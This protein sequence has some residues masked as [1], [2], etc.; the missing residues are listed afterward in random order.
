MFNTLRTHMKKIFL[1]LIVLILPAFCF[2][3]IG[4]FMRDETRK[5]AG[6][7]YGKKI[8][9]GDLAKMRSECMLSALILYGKRYGDLAQY[10]D[11]NKQAWERMLLLDEARRLGISISDDELAV[12]LQSL[13][14]VEGKFDKSRYD[15]FVKQTGVNPIILERN[16]RDTMTIGRLT[17]TIADSAVVSAK[18]IDEALER[19]TE[20]RT[21]GYAALKDTTYKRDDIFVP[22]Q[23]IQAYYAANGWEF[24]VPDKVKAAY[25]FIP[26][27]DFKKKISVT[28][29]EAEAFYQTNKD[30]FRDEQ[31]AVAP[32]FDKIKD[33]LKARLVD[34]KAIDMAFEKATDISIS[35]LQKPD[36]AAAAQANGYAVGQA[37]YFSQ[38]QPVPGVEAAEEFAAAAF[39]TPVG[40]ISNAVKTAK[41][42]YIVQNLD[43]KPSYM[44]ALSDIKDQVAAKV[45]ENKKQDFLKEN[46]E[47]IARE[48]R[49]KVSKDKMPFDEAAKSMGLDAAKTAAFKMTD[50]LETLTA[51]EKEAAFTIG[52]GDVSSPVRGP[53]YYMILS[54]EQIDSPDLSKLSDERLKLRD[55]LLNIKRDKVISMWYRAL[56]QRAQMVDMTDVKK[57]QP[58]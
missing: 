27:D 52:K 47:R 9:T 23:D 3:G 39:E 18:E 54:V 4:S 41:G 30:I 5:T 24:R 38:G 6:M 34:Q 8:S 32:P 40:K 7:M 28:D 57:V 51:K 36:L 35:L 53:D 2:W 58:E 43:R 49:D 10:I 29:K 14:S 16:V 42:F 15:A 25:L 55:Q 19:I 33:E 22:D 13:F 46:A 48:L 44:P 17:R 56:R 1:A 50:A 20:K 12:Q 31:T 45:R 11:F 26:F 21:V 37:D